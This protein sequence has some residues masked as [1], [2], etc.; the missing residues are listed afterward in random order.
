MSGDMGK[1]RI[2]PLRHPF[3]HRLTWEYLF[4]EKSSASGH[5]GCAVLMRIRSQ[6]PWQAVAPDVTLNAYQ[7]W[8]CQNFSQLWCALHQHLRQMRSQQSQ[9]A[10]HGPEFTETEGVRAADAEGIS[11][12]MN[13]SNVH[14]G[15]EEG[16]IWLSPPH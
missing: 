4:H 7:P 1:V 14:R 11:S 10:G 3:T 8:I 5:H 13:L 6:C 15:S 16:K 2:S 9:K 12:V